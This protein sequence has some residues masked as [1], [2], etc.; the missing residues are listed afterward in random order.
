MSKAD[1]LA[2]NAAAG[3]LR[4]KDP[5]IRVR[6][7]I[8]FFAYA[9]GKAPEGLQASQVELRAALARWGFALNLPACAVAGPAGAE[10]FAAELEAARGDLPYDIDGC[11]VNLDPIAPRAGIGSTSRAPRWAVARKFAAEEA[12]M[13]L[14][15]VTWQVGP[16]GVITPVAELAPVGVGGVLVARATLHNV[17]EIERLGVRLGGRIRIRCT[18]DVISQV[19]GALDKEGTIPAVPEVCSRCAGPLRIRGASDGTRVLCCDAG[20]ACD[21]QRRAALAHAVSRDALDIDELGPERLA[22][23]DAEGLVREPA[24]L[25]SL[26]ARDAQRPDGARLSDADGWGPQSA[27]ALFHSI[28]QRRR[29]PLE[30]LLVV[31]GIPE[32]GE[33]LA[34]TLADA[35]GRFE[36]RDATAR[37]AA[38]TLDALERLCALPRVGHA[39]ARDIVLRGPVSIKINAPARKALEAAFPKPADLDALVADVRGGL[40]AAGRLLAIDDVSLHTVIALARFFQNAADSALR[41]ASAFD[42]LP[43]ERPVAGPLAGLIVVFTGTLSD[44]QPKLAAEARCLG[45]EVA[46]GV[47]ARTSLLVAGE[48]AGSKQARAEALGIPVLNEAT[49]ART[50]FPSPHLSAAS[51]RQV[52]LHGRS[53]NASATGRTSQVLQ[54]QARF[55]RSVDRLAGF[56]ADAP[57]WLPDRAPGSLQGHP[58]PSAQ[59]GQGGGH[60]APSCAT[61]PTE[62]F[63]CS[64]SMPPTT[65]SA[66]ATDSRRS[67][68][69]TATVVSTA[70]PR[71][72]ACVARSQ[73]SAPWPA[74]APSGCVASSRSDPSCVPSAQ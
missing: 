31:T 62:T 27:Q 5:A 24:D 42:V 28:A 60:H 32:V 71:L 18:G 66:T 63:S 13:R 68:G 73:S 30:R 48:K 67:I 50:T 34:R 22:W 12:I 16:T 65:A 20:L 8:D 41:L 17:S 58:S 70:P 74:A 14:R 35:F 47:S 44:P 57:F 36:E 61:G 21:D 2:L 49:L 1:F 9:L 54:F 52:D 10:T 4:Q 7:P 46:D 51:Q 59:D 19:M 3:A 23:L 64:P 72:P 29:V 11:V 53:R 38:P 26:A 25:F 40:D 6:R 33:S 37:A 56:R 43:P 39:M 69:P 55:H 45:V 15:A